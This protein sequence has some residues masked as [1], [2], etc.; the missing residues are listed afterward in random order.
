MKNISPGYPALLLALLVSITGCGTDYKKEII[1]NWIAVENNCDESGNCKSDEKVTGS[2]GYMA[3]G[4]MTVGGVV[5]GKYTIQGKKIKF[6]LF[7]NKV[8]VPGETE[9]LYLKKNILLS[10][11][12]FGSD[13]NEQNK[14]IKGL[15]KQEPFIVKYKKEGS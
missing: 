12:T 7:L 3:D 15:V 9:I 8:E 10:R 6:I 13:M 4:R 1:G 5:G 2:T 11:T 14:E